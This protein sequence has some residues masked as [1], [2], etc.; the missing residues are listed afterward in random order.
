MDVAT[1]AGALSS[2]ISAISGT[3]SARKM[4]ASTKLRNAM[5]TQTRLVL[6]LRRPPV[7]D[8]AVDIVQRFLEQARTI[9]NAGIKVPGSTG[10]TPPVAIRG[11]R[12]VECSRP[13]NV[14]EHSGVRY[15]ERKVRDES[16]KECDEVGAR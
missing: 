1:T 10:W 11:E 16:L 3:W 5:L 7:G 13:S 15:G 2:P 8:N 6:T 14:Y 12:S 4:S 9:G